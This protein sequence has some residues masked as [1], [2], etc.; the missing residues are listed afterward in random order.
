MQ[1]VKTLSRPDELFSL[2]KI[3]YTESF[4]PKAQLRGDLDN[5]EWC[6]ELLNKTSRSFAFV[7]NELDPTLKDAICVFY[8]V[9][10]GLD[11]V[12]DDTTVPLPTKLPVLQRFAEGLYQPGFKVFGYGMN[13]DEKHLAENFDKVSS[14]RR[15][16]CLLRDWDLYCHYVAGLVGIGLSK[17]FAASGLESQ[18]FATAD[19]E[20]NDMGLFLQKTNII[21]DYLE[22]INES[23]IFWPREIWSK[24]SVKLENFK[25]PQYASSALCCLNDLITNALQHAIVSLDYMAR[26]TNAKVVGFCAI[27][28]VMAIATLSACYNNHGVFTGVV[29]IRKGQRALIVDIIQNKGIDGTFELFHKFAGE[30][31][32]KVPASDPN[33]KKT[34]ESLATIQRICVNKLGYKPAAFNDFGNYDWMAVASI[35][36][37]SAFLVA[38]HGPN[39]FSKL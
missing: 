4:K 7:I 25:N 3:G 13:N 6:Y 32:A 22:D 14:C 39:I 11:T 15:R 29:K 37:S 8:L 34:L 18:W 16:S 21:R 9:L 23:R 17:I 27:P 26:L 12:E 38:R 31:V 5:K 35:A 19:K 20:S 24:Y 10:R 28:Q 1:Y 2:L 30:M 33:A 36:A